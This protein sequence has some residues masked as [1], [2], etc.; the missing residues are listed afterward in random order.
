MSELPIIT[1]YLL[2][3]KHFASIDGS[4]KGTAKKTAKA[5]HSPKYFGLESGLSVLN[6]LLDNMVV[7]SDYIS[8]N[9]YE[10][11]QIY[12]LYFNHDADFDPEIIAMDTHGTNQFNFCL[13]DIINIELAICYKDI[14]DRT[15]QLCGFKPLKHY[16]GMLIKPGKVSNI[17][18]IEKHDDKIRDIMLSI[19]T[20]KTKQNTLIKKL[21]HHGRKTKLKKAAWEYNNIFFTRFV[22]NYINDPSLQKSIRATLNRGETSN[23]FYN[24]IV[25]IGGKKFKGKSEAQIRIENQATRLLMLIISFYNMYLLSAAIELKESQNDEQAI[26]IFSKISPLATQHMN[27]G[28]TY[29][30]GEGSNINIEEM[31]AALTNAVDHLNYPKKQEKQSK[32]KIK[33]GDKE[34]VTNKN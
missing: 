9:E 31:I 32:N 11:H 23:K 18:L 7:N 5:R 26:K 24:S 8:C 21:C 22:L 27:L 33:G 29:Y 15:K 16:E 3:G 10:G 14:F 6:M 4:K 25:K 13:F 34:N 30:Y 20:K 12:D 17:K 1:R 2:A 28:G 19:L